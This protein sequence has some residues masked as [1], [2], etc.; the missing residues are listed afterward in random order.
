[1][2][3]VSGGTAKSTMWVCGMKRFGLCC[4][5]ALNKDDWRLRIKWA[6]G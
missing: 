5:D 6:T 3:I 4:K 2:L 1:M